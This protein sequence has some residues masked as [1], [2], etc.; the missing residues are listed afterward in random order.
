[1]AKKQEHNPFKPNT[2]YVLMKLLIKAFNKGQLFYMVFSIIALIAII[3]IPGDE[4]LPFFK[5]VLK[6]SENYCILGWILFI[7]VALVSTLM[8]SYQNKR[9]KAEIDRISAQK[10]ELQR[11]LSGT[12]LPSTD[13]DK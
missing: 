12:D 7:L 6:L 1:M 5:D 10:T 8:I 4:I 13:I 9:H 2:Q 3:K 11:H